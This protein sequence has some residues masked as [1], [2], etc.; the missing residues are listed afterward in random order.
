MVKHILKI[1]LRNYR[2]NLLF[3]LIIVSGLAV[4]I[5]TIM[6][7]TRFVIQEYSTD[8]F[9][10]EYKNIFRVLNENSEST[11]SSVIQDWAE[12][13]KSGYPDVRE[14]CCIDNIEMDVMNSTGP[15]RLTRVLSTD[16]AF[17][18][19]F[20]F[21]ASRGDSAHPFND[22]QSIV[23][24]ESTAKKLFGTIEAVGK[25][26]NSQ[27]EQTRIPLTVTLVTKDP[28]EG[29]RIQF[30][31]LVPFENESFHFRSLSFCMPGKSNERTIIYMCDI[32]LLLHEKANISLINKRLKQESFRGDK[33]SGFF[34]YLRL[35]P[36]S[37]A[38]FDK[39]QDDGFKH[40]DKPMLFVFISLAVLLLLLA[41][42]NYIN[43]TT[44]KAF[45]RTREIAFKKVCGA[46]GNGLT[47]QFLFESVG[48][49]VMS[50]L[51]AIV[52]SKYLAGVFGKLVNSSLDVS[53][54]F[55]SPQIFLVLA[56]SI[57][58]GIV[59]GYYPAVFLSR[60]R[61]SELF[62]GQTLTR[63]NSLFL[64]K[65]LFILQ[66]AIAISLIVSVIVI[67][68]QLH[69]IRTKDL[70]FNKNQLLHLSVPSEIKPFALQAELLKNPEISQVTLTYGT[71]GKLAASTGK[72]W[73]IAVDSSFLSTFG[74]TLL[75]GRNFTS[76]DE[77]V[78]LVNE[79]LLKENGWTGYRGRKIGN[80]TVI[81]VVKDFHTS[82]FY[83][84][85]VP[86]E[87]DY[88]LSYL[89][90]LTVR[91]S[92]NNAAVTL[93]AIRN[94]WKKMAP[95][96][97]FGYYFYDE[98]FDRQ[99][100]KEEAFSKLITLFTFIAILIS[101]LGLFGLLA[102]LI[103]R[104]A[105]EI[106]LRKING[107]SIAEIMMLLNRDFIRWVAVA[108]IVAIPVSWYILS[109]WLANFAYKTAL[110]WWIFALAGLIAVGIALLTVS[111]KSWMA[112]G[113]NP[114]ETIREE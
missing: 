29:S 108:F 2:K 65:H 51:L 94:T 37:D 95:Y 4:S 103:E 98:W 32:Y 86:L 31:A 100:R 88:N 24:T 14:V 97:S 77:N 73:Y 113:R 70:G 64:P 101:C 107:A 48:L 81:G 46:T 44:I 90:D 53:Y 91:M 72:N 84:K 78:C 17:F 82:S 34:S 89:P 19:V 45:S 85:I 80:N 15:V 104:R 23:I 63:R 18:S 57:V 1:T 59:S 105:R 42:F 22:R 99:Y 30:E 56:F 41:C 16:P 12:K 69:Y 10:K 75:E 87:M 76:A 33:E 52:L 20:S 6:V 43:L 110:S 109:R 25:V 35:Q 68:K 28:P 39:N 8:T 93:D 60:I 74:M 71:P 92:S 47:G 102:Y 27:I 50:F 5:A 58:L 111:W 61:A 13:L 3:T 83:E 7:I 55:Q 54:F 106:G 49:S 79:T 11:T 40:G 66:F 67:E 114:V 21:P 9:H 36:N 62:K 38:Y 112:A 96:S 26:I